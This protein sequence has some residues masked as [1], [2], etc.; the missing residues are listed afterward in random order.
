MF[1][2]TFRADLSWHSF[3][4]QGFEEFWSSYYDTYD[5]RETPDASGAAPEALKI[6]Q[7]I[8]KQEGG[9]RRK[10]GG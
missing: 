6:Y 2:E 5:P 3:T 9:G 1:Q 7:D 10:E 4:C 8:V